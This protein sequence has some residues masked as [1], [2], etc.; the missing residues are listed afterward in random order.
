MTH[1]LLFLRRLTL[2]AGS[3]VYRRP[4]LLKQQKLRIVSLMRT[5][6]HITL[7]A[8]AE[9]HVGQVR[10]VNQD[11]FLCLPDDGAF[12]VADGMG[13]HAGGEVA[14]M[15]CILAIQTYIASAAAQR[16]PTS[17]RLH[18]DQTVFEL[19]AQAVTHASDRI[20]ERSHDDRA[21][22]GM[23]TTA[24]VF[25]VVDDRGYIAHVGDSR[26][27][28]YREG[29]LKQLTI[30]HSWVNEQLNAGLLTPEEA[31]FHP[32]R[33]VITRSVGYE[34]AVKVDTDC[35]LLQNNDFILLC[36]DG[37]SG[38]VADVEISQAVRESGVDAVDSLIDLANDRGGDD[39]ITVVVVR[40]KKRG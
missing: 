23:G 6:P 14:S 33:N 7:E 15:L 40:I 24:T 25:K 30:D 4:Q 36:S 2:T 37:L 38:K 16:L 19:L 13:G 39:N 10:T 12:V 21:L 11:A 5:T 32:Y 9:T 26:L 20:Y 8:R 28:L 35:I 18:P 27:Y 1:F 17:K 22:S 3:F 29:Q 31:E 34:D